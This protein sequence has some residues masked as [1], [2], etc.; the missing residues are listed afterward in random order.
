MEEL[1]S[2]GRSR[3]VVRLKFRHGPRDDGAA[4]LG[5]VGRARRGHGG[6]AQGSVGRVPRG[7]RR[8]DRHYPDSVRALQ[9]ET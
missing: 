3:F 4:E 7:F 6:A 9:I 2:S 8:V 5:Q 1:T